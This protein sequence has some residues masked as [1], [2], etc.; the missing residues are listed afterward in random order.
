MMQKNPY[1]GKFIVFEGLDG[2]GQSTQTKLLGSFSEKKGY[3]V[4]LTKEPTLD[5]RAGRRIREALDEKISIEPDELQQLFAQD[6]KE[7]LEKLIIPNL[8]KGKIV[9]SDRYFFSSFAYGSIDLDLNWLIELNKDFILP[10]IIFFLEVR[11]EICLERIEKRGERIALFEKKEKLEKVWR[12]YKQVLDRF[13]NVYIINGEE[14]IEEVFEQIK[15]IVT[16][17][18]KI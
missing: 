4:I 3:Q 12:N 1:P 11:P 17:E 2:S 16:K 7:H 8:K 10:D 14:S 6:R 9:I 18:L 15:K 5:S 13:D